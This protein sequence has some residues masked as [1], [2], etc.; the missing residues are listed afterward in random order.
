MTVRELIQRL[1]DCDQ[2][3]T[4]VVLIESNGEVEAEGVRERLDSRQVIVWGEYD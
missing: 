2:D 1:L 4:V 3:H